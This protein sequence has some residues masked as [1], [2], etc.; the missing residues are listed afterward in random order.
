M[1]FLI[2]SFAFLSQ[3]CFTSLGQTRE[4]IKKLETWNKKCLDSGVNMLGCSREY[5]LKMDTMLNVVYFNLYKKMSPQVQSYLK[6]EQRDWLNKRDDY[7]KQ[8]NKKVRKKEKQKEAGRDLYMLVYQ[9][10]AEFIKI[11]ILE[12][13]NRLNKTKF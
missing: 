12:L 8:Q 9:E 11:R 10:D 7:F 5:Y 2:I 4:D 1:K 6:K 13:I 3:F